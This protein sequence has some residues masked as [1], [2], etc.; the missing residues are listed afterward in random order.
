MHF[1][2]SRYLVNMFVF[3][4]LAENERAQSALVWGKCSVMLIQGF[5]TEI[6]WLFTR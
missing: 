2:Q 1:I 3:N 5:N 4:R 6:P